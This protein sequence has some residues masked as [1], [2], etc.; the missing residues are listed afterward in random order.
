MNRLVYTHVEKKKERKKEDWITIQT[1]EKGKKIWN[2]QTAITEKGLTEKKKKLKLTE[3]NWMK[4]RGKEYIYI[5]IYIYR[6]FNK[7]PDV[8]CRRLLKIQYII[9][10]HLMRW[11]TNIYDSRFKLT[12]TEAIGIHPTKAWLSQLVNLKNAIWM[13]EHFRRTICNK[14]LYETWKKCY[15]NVWN[16]S[17]CFWSILH[18]SISSFWVASEIQGRQGVCEGWWE[19]WEE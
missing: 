7:F 17:D 4:D 19:V 15:R 9:A 11:L 2:K 18:E 16:V 10:I 14:I 6:A 8:F 13:W 12:A 3:K 5:Y 1:E